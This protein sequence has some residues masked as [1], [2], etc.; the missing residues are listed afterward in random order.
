MA[1]IYVASRHDKF[2]RAIVSKRSTTGGGLKDTFTKSQ[3]GH[4]VRRPMHGM[5][6][7]ED[8][9]ASM[10]IITP[11]G[12][13]KNAL[14]NTSLS[15]TESDGL[16]SSYTTN[17]IVQSVAE[18]KAERQQV[19]QTFGDDYVYFYG[20]QPVTLTVEALLPDSQEFQYA[21]EFWVNYG[22]ALRGTR[23]V[24]KNAR[25]YL[26]VAGQV[27]EGYLTTASTSKRADSPRLINLNFSMYVTNSYY[28]RA[29]TNEMQVGAETH[30]YTEVKQGDFV[31]LGG[32]SLGLSDELLSTQPIEMSNM[33]RVAESVGFG[34][35]VDN[36]RSLNGAPTLPLDTDLIDL[37]SSMDMKRLSVVFT[38]L[39]TE[40]KLTDAEL[41]KRADPLVVP[42]KS[43]PGG[44][45]SISF[46]EVV[47]TTLA[48]AAGGLIVAGIVKGVQDDYRAYVAGGGR[49]GIGG[50]AFNRT[51]QPVFD[52]AEEIVDSVVD[53][54]TQLR[55]AGYQV[56]RPDRTPNNPGIELRTRRGTNTE[57]I[58]NIVLDI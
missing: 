6:V 4:S 48:I 7:P 15:K 30:K 14:Y 18:S 38:E 26:T 39:T 54:A 56:I 21:Q 41:V 28:V 34:Q 20:Q 49:N 10:T 42:L 29:L 51:V 36:I 57:S 25:M 35:F 58:D 9:Y 33:Y 19:V 50:Y 11:S 40:V 12:K 22:S 44:D 46:A 43:K 16:Q 24:L 5:S 23:L 31:S 32:E 53:T 8:S 2:T 52:A 45:D 1:K 37:A 47:S 27:F 3:S 13:E 55:N 17:F